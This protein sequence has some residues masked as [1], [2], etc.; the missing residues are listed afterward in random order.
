L[1]NNPLLSALGRISADIIWG[2]TYEN[3]EG[4]KRKISK[5][6]EERGKKKRKWEVKE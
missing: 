3:G 4:K 2:K 5:K 1:E 6:K